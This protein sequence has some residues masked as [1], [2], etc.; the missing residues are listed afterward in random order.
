MNRQIRLLQLLLVLGSF[1]ALP[2]RAQLG[3]NLDIK[4]PEP[5]DNRTL[6][7]EKTPDK[8]INTPKRLM[9]NMV[10]HYNYF[11]NA[12]AKL[13]EV[14]EAAKSQHKDNYTRLLPFYNYTLDATAGQA[15]VLDSVIIKSKTGI[16]LHDLR[17]DWVDNLYLLWGAAYYFE[18]KFD[19][20]YNMFQFI[21]WAFAD[22]EKDGYYRYI[23]SSLDR[24]NPNQI[25]SPEK[26]ETLP[27]RAFNEPPSRNDALVWQVRTLIRQGAYV[28]SGSL[29]SALRN[30][31]AF[32]ARLKPEL[33]EVQA[34]WYYMQQVWDSSAYH[35]VNALNAAGTRQER[36]RWEFLAAQL[37]ERT[38]HT[39][40]AKSWYNKSIDHTTDPVM[41]VYARLNLIR[42]NKEGG[43][44][45][46]DRNVATLVKMARKDKYAEYRDVIYSM[47]A[48]ME[49]ERGN[50]VAAQEYL[51]K[52]GRYKADNA[53]ANNDAYLA[54]ADRT[55]DSRQYRQAA[56]FYDSVKLEGL[57]APDS[58]RVLE[59]RP[60]LTR[61]V[62]FAGTVDRQDSLQR[63]A[64]MSDDERKDFIRKIVRQLRRAKGLKDEANAQASRAAAPAP[65]MFGAG[66]ATKGEWYFYNDNARKTGL[67]NFRAIWGDRPNVDN[68]RRATDVAAQLRSRQP[69]ATRNT[70][71]AGSAA[72]AEDP[73]SYEALVEDIPLT[74]DAMKRS[75]DSIQYALR[76][77][78]Q[79]YAGDMNDYA[80]SVETL[81][82][83]RRRYPQP[84]SLEQVLFG[85]Y[86]GYT[87]TGNTA[88]AEEMKRLLQQQF[89]KGRYTAIATTGLDPNSGRQQLAAT[90]QAYEEIYDMYLSG[91]FAEA[92]AAKQRADSQYRTNTWNPQL[93]YIQ[94]VAQIKQQQDSLALRTLST[95]IAQNPKTVIADKAQTMVRVLG[96]RKQ[97]EE[98]LRNLQ[99][100]RPKEDTLYVEPMP[101]AKDVQQQTIVAPRKD[102]IAVVKTLPKKPSGIDTAALRKPVLVPPA[103]NSPFRFSPDSAHWAVVVLSN[104]DIVYGNEARNAFSRYNS[105]QGRNF[106]S[107]I[108][109]VNDATKLLLIGPFA[110]ATDA[111]NYVL[112]VKPIAASQIVPWLKAGS[113]SYS[114]IS[115]GN[116]NAVKNAKSIDAYRDFLDKTLPVK[117]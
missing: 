113:Y 48:Q 80:A 89:P 105:S 49:L 83:L 4:K 101:V 16:V 25:S 33:E 112:T 53:T 104:V 19:S 78:A 52:S 62:Y 5:F 9:Q 66:P 7:S 38:G 18:K 103:P 68:W 108:E 58:L 43:D 55:Y 77:L 36:A 111:A 1:F 50:F 42:I 109:P 95:L 30:D 56:F 8:R 73:L 6:K 99:V 45:Y 92:E 107:R 91:R 75:N 69:E 41:D 47:L 31:P 59:R 106:D 90:T 115:N 100:E 40:E 85:L 63:I 67:A 51:K 81:E 2:A 96:R 35:L 72:K 3:F 29:I 82:A 110:N 94:A 23:G 70:A 44:N 84:D 93:L 98:E 17:N 74:P 102:T 76:G 64:A 54:L 61:L 114:I 24:N 65:D 46:I 10:T 21:N 12:N 37:F 14:M 20:A 71:K 79:L 34:H 39:E 11:F 97:I 15:A 116:L 87:R 28:E 60:V 86:H 88:K 32:P 27:R 13:N 57:D 22:K 26:K 117:L